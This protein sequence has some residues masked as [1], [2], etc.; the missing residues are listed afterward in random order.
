[1]N[2]RSP[3]ILELEKHRRQAVGCPTSPEEGKEGISDAQ[4][5]QLEDKKQSRKGK[6]LAEKE[7][8]SLEKWTDIWMV[9]FPS[10]PPPLFPC[11][12]HPTA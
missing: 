9:L 7:K 2:D 11:K 6:G 5:V 3:A 10:T 4:W 12:Q 1:M 8:S